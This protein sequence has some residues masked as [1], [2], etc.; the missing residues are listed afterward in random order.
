MRLNLG[1]V[2][3]ETV[4]GVRVVHV[5]GDFF[6][7]MAVCGVDSVGNLFRLFFKKLFLED[8]FLD[9]RRAL[10]ELAGSDGVDAVGG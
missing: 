7:S 10:A 6:G 4:E 8:L 3:V 1:V 9:Y 5:D 2:F